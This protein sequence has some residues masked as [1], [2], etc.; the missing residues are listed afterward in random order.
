MYYANL[1]YYRLLREKW[2]YY[3]PNYREY[4]VADG[5]R[6]LKRSRPVKVQ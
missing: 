1:Q 4:E 2:I 6:D 3:V 5:T